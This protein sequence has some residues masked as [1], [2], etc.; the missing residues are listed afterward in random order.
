MKRQKEEEKK[1]GKAGKYKKENA[2]RDNKRG[3]A[4]TTRQGAQKSP[5]LTD[6]QGAQGGD[7]QTAGP[8][9]VAEPVTIDTASS[10]HDHEKEGDSVSN[11]SAHPKN[12][13]FQ[14]QEI[15][16]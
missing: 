8:A 9:S 7:N 2:K 4:L 12:I 3:G 6:S 14:D 5:P 10:K 11:A 13:N 1:K 15:S 16:N